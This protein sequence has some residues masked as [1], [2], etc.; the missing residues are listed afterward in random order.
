MTG[1]EIPPGAPIVGRDAFRT[2]TGVHASAILK[3]SRRGDEELVD[4]VYSAV[5]A[6]WLGRQ[7]EI[8][9]GPMSGA[10]NIRSW[11]LDHGYTDD[12]GAVLRVLAAAKRADRTLTDDELHALVAGAPTGRA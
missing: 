6:A 2:S 4:L 9:V 7:Q 8:E 1:V 11:L 10:S 5:P 3:A 12:E